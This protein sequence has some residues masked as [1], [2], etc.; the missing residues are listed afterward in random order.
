M[1]E[2]A[3]DRSRISVR[4]RDYLISV[5]NAIVTVADIHVNRCYCKISGAA[6]GHVSVIGPWLILS[7]MYI[8]S[9][10]PLPWLLFLLLPPLLGSNIKS[11]LDLIERILIL[12]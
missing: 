9:I 1:K 8:L 11:W 12:F 10:N 5:T 7:Y 2:Y 3:S 4:I 6:V